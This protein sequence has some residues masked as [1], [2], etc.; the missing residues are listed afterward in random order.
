MERSANLVQMR[1]HAVKVV[2]F[3]QKRHGGF[4]HNARNAGNFVRLI[5]H[6]RLFIDDLQGLQPHFVFE[7]LFGEFQNIAHA[8]AGVAN[9]R[10]FVNELI[11]ITIARLDIAVHIELFRQRTDDVVRFVALELTNADTHESKHLF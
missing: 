2:V 10:L 1:V 6:Q 11:R 7:I 5:A 3:F 8:L 4:L 9:V